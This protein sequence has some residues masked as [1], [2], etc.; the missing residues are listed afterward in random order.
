MLH[1]VFAD[2]AMVTQ[3]K[4]LLPKQVQIQLM[5]RHNTNIVYMVLMQMVAW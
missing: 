2:V 3:E 1:E 4:N 5:Q